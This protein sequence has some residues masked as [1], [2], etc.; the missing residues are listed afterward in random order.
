MSRWGFGAD[1]PS[2]CRESCPL[3]PEA[4]G[5]KEGF[6]GHP[7]CPARHQL[8]VYS[9][10]GPRPLHLGRLGLAAKDRF[11]PNPVLGSLLECLPPVVYLSLLLC[12]MGPWPCTQV[13]EGRL[14]A[15]IPPSAPACLYPL[16]P[17]SWSSVSIATPIAL[18]PERT[19]KLLSQSMS[20]PCLK[21]AC[22]FQSQI[23]QG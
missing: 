19:F 3:P 22:S 1:I 14:P 17:P 11:G 20:L 4:Q 8:G 5:R 15:S 13:P 7:L 12:E 10:V 16:S 23:K 2:G 21:S 6:L 18:Q 9:S